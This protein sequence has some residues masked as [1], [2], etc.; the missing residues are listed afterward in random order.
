MI[1]LTVIAYIFAYVGS[2]ERTNK[3]V[4]RMLTF[5]G[6]IQCLV[7]LVVMALSITGYVLQIGTEGPGFIILFLYVIGFGI[8]TA[9]AG[10]LLS[11]FDI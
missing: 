4:R 9:V 5:I 2:G 1:A 10:D 6:G 7:M 8:Y 11:Q 3:I